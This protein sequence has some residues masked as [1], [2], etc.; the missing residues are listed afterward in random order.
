MKDQ[1]KD[2]RRGGKPSAPNRGFRERPPAAKGR[3]PARAGD[4]RPRRAPSG[5]DRPQRKFDGERPQRSLGGDRPQRS[6]GD[7]PQRSFGA[8]PQRDDRRRDDAP[9]PAAARHG[10][11]WR[12]TARPLSGTSGTP[13]LER[14]A[15]VMARAGLCSRRE[16]EEWITGGRVSVNGKPID[17]PALD[18]GP[19]DVILVDNKPLPA[20]ERT[21][22]WLYHKPRGLVTTADDPEGRA[23]V[24]DNLP[25]EL[26]RVISV[27]RLDINTEGLLLLTNDGGLARVLGHPS[28]GWLRRYR[29]RAHGKTTQDALDDLR[30]GVTLDGIDYEPIVATLDRQKGDNCWLTMDLTEGKNREVKR[31][32]EHLGLAVSRLIRISF[33]PFQLGDL[34]EGAIDEIRTRQIKDQLGPRLAEEAGVDFDAPL[35]GGHEAVAPSDE[36]RRKRYLSK[37]GFQDRRRKA[38][39]GEDENLKLELG[40]VADRKG[41]TVKVE[42][43]KVIEPEVEETSRQPRGDRPQRA[44]GGFGGGAPRQGRGRPDGDRPQRS[45]GDRPQGSRS[46]GGRPQSG[47]PG[48]FGGGGPRGGRS[49]GGYSG[50][51]SFGGDRPQRSFGGRPQGSRP[52]GGRPQ[53]GRPGG[54]GGGGPRGERSEGGYSGGR[55]FGGDRPQRSFG[56][57]PQGGRPGGFGAGRPG[58]KFGGGKPGGG[59]PFGGRPGGGRSPGGRP[60]GGKPPRRNG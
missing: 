15:K 29:V 30:R 17:S 7:R 36:P 8:P 12:E 25:P 40:A 55:S 18:V 35:F 50:G 38:T 14:I 23:T 6:F 16:A 2:K 34:G 1:D 31:I 19:Q 54:F 57:R 3:A 52:E 33:G 10:T 49:E 28:T 4:D 37:E 22:L 5:D 56:D 45:F 41:R 26:P 21:R 44:H 11:S 27:G 59:K 53:G 9:A 48:G 47:R 20:R 60:P 13:G 24:F 39:A 58:G 42:R 43:I 51:R 46:E 32:L